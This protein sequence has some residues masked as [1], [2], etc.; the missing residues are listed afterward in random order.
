MILIVGGVIGYVGA[1]AQKGDRCCGQGKEEKA[2]HGM[3]IDQVKRRFI[4]LFAAI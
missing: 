4:P 2:F 3:T 1:A